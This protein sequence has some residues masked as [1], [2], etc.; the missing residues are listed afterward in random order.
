MPEFKFSTKAGTLYSLAGHLTRAYLP[1][2]IIVPYGEW[3]SDTDA[4]LANIV[5]RFSGQRLA[6]RSSAA[7]EDTQ[8]A[9]MAGAHLSLINM[10]CEKAALQQAI[11]DVFGS[12]GTAGLVDEVLVQPMVEDTVVAGVVL[13]RDLDTGA[14]YYVINYDDF[15][16]LNGLI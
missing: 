5:S 4:V 10:D 1:D 15:I 13:T 9:S 14:P 7:N 6:V 8:S 12:Y 2:Q 11:D 16:Y 3:R